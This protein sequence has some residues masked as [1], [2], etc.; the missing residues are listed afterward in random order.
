MRVGLTDADFGSVRDILRRRLR[1]LTSRPISPD[2]ADINGE[3]H[4]RAASTMSGSFYFGNTG[5]TLFQMWLVVSAVLE[6]ERVS[7]SDLRNITLQVKLKARAPRIQ[8]GKF[9]PQRAD[10]LRNRKG[11]RSH[12]V[13]RAPRCGLL[14]TPAVNTVVL[15]LTAN[16]H[17]CRLALTLKQ[18]LGQ[19]NWSGCI[20]SLA[21]EWL[22]ASVQLFH[23]ELSRA[24]NPDCTLASVLPSAGLC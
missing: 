3:R 23:A 10:W 9:P 17:D 13:G 20:F 2:L 7:P 1:W 11:P 19:N 4:N 22:F 15:M 6:Q 16:I 14:K 24:S 21:F 18:H 5:N 12:L 8:R